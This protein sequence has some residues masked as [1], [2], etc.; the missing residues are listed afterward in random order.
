[1]FH[2]DFNLLTIRHTTFIYNFKRTLRRNGFAIRSLNLLS[3]LIQSR[4]IYTVIISIKLMLADCKSL[5]Y[6]R[7]RIA[8]LPRRNCL[9]NK[10]FQLSNKAR[11]TNLR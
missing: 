4:F 8:N 3:G 2:D 11:I 6:Q 5:S 10:L 7:C 9:K 1:L